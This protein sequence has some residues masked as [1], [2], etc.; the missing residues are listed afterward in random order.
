MLAVTAVYHFE[1]EKYGHGTCFQRDEKDAVWF[2]VDHQMGSYRLRQW[3]GGAHNFRKHDPD[4]SYWGELMSMRR[5][6]VER[7]HKP[8]FG[9]V[10]CPKPLPGSE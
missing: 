5:G 9:P 8:G 6:Y 10:V 4:E 3:L 7:G 1:W 2:V